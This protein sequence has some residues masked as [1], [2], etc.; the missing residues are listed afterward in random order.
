MNHINHLRH[1]DQAIQETQELIE[2]CEA[3]KETEPPEELPVIE[4]DIATLKA[5]LL[6]LETERQNMEHH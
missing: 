5:T 3:S 4:K 6:R 1:I 2:F